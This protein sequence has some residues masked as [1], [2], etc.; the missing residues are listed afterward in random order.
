LFLVLRHLGHGGHAALVFFGQVADQ[1]FGCQY[2]G[3]DAGCVLEGGAGNEYYVVL[4]QK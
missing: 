3:G 1:R 4:M 2:H